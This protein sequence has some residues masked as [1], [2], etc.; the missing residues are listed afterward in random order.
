MWDT[1]KND[2]MWTESPKADEWSVMEW[3]GRG[4]PTMAPAYK[5]SEFITEQQVLVK[6]V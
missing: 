3:I 5:F 6:P 1:P 4:R 2:K